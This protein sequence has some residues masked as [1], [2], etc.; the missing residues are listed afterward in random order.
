MVSI[1]TAAGKSGPTPNSLSGVRRQ[2]ALGR[3][4]RPHDRGRGQDKPKHA[5]R[6]RRRVKADFDR[7][8]TRTRVT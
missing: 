7:Q 4:R 3:D 8:R 6:Q 1:E 2:L 5:D